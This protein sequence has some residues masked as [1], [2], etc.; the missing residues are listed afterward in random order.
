MASSDSVESTRAERKKAAISR[1]MYE[2][3]DTIPS[4]LKLE[5]IEIICPTS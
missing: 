2:A 5:D 1:C 4:S 3:L